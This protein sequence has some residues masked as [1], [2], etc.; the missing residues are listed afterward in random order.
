ML[1]ERHAENFLIENKFSELDVDTSSIQA[2]QTQNKT[3]TTIKVEITAGNDVVTTT[4]Q[5]EKMK[6]RLQPPNSQ[7]F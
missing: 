4:H 3:E 7:P 2:I 6:P 1:V 5:P